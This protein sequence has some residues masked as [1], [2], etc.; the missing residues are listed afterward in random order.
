M[1]G[2]TPRD[3]QIADF[4]AAEEL[5]ARVD[6]CYRSGHRYNDPEDPDRCVRCGY[7]L[8]ELPLAADDI[9]F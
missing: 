9:P 2:P 8:P 6:E 5:T 3:R 4:L 7:L 1:S